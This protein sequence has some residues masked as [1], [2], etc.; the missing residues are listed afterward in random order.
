MCLYRGCSRVLSSKWPV[1]CAPTTFSLCFGLIFVRGKLNPAN[2][3]GL[4]F[5]KYMPVSNYTQS[6]T[7]FLLFI[8]QIT[9]HKS[10]IDRCE[11]LA[12]SPK[13]QK[14]NTYSI[15]D[16]LNKMVSLLILTL[17]LFPFSL[18]IAFDCYITLTQ[19]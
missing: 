8:I 17:E 15:P 1:V 3:R 6:N 14:I 2:R 7:K 10:H 19:S 18:E 4:S 5:R 11:D 12:A 16:E 13:H 9:L